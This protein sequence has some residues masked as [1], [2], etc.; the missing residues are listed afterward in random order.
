MSRLP[1]NQ[2]LQGDALE[3]LQRLPSQAVEQVIT[4]PPYFRLR[5]YGVDVIRP[6][7]SAYPVFCPA[8]AGR[9]DSWSA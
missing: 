2:I 8:L 4:S 5:D 9:S 3:R 6:G 7:F 1:R